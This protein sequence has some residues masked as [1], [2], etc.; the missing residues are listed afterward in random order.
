MPKSIASQDNLRYGLINIQN[1]FNE[2]TV[3]VMDFLSNPEIYVVGCSGP[4][5]MGCI[6]HGQVRPSMTDC[7]PCVL[8]VRRTLIYILSDVGSA[9]V[10]QYLQSGVSLHHHYLIFTMLLMVSIGYIKFNRQCYIW[11]IHMVY[12]QGKIT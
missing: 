8:I 9:V 11:Y 12:F 5:Y 1:C 10:R 3:L 6:D 2:I 7:Y 4:V